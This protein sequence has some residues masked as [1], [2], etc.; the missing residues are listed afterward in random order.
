MSYLT[1]ELGL[2]I[3]KEICNRMI[4]KEDNNDLKSGRSAHLGNTMS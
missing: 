2:D 1:G 3:S 4:V